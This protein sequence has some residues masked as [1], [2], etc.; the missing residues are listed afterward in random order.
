MPD[1]K[2]VEDP[3][4]QLTFSV[5]KDDEGGYVQFI[6][7]YYYPNQVLPPEL[8]VY[9][10]FYGYNHGRERTLLITP[11]HE[12]QW[13]S[14]I[15]IAIAKMASLN[16][17]V[18]SNTPLRIKRT[19]EWLLNAGAG[20]GVFGWVPFMAAHLG[21]YLGLGRA[22]I[23]IE[24]ATPANG[25]QVIN[26][27]HLNPLRCRLT[28]D[29]QYPVHYLSGDGVRKL[30]WHQVMVIVDMLDPTEGEM[31]LTMGATERAYKSIIKMAAID[32]YV[33]EKVSGARP[34]ALYFLGGAV[35][36]HIKDAIEGSELDADRK[37]IMS[38]RGAA[39][40]AVPGDIPLTL[41][42]IPLAELPDGFDADQERDRADLIYANAIGL[43][44]QDINPSLVGR[45][46]LGSSGNQSVVLA[47]KQRGR[48]LSAWMAQFSHA[49]NEL[50][51]NAKVLFTFSDPSP[52]EKQSE[53]DLSK[54]RA[55]TRKIQ[56]ETGEITPDQ[57]RNL[58]VD[59]GDLPREF[60]EV[61][62]TGG[63][64]L[65]DDAKILA[66]VKPPAGEGETG[67]QGEG[68]MEAL[69]GDIEAFLGT[70]TD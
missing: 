11:R 28:G 52:E 35:Q 58:A 69:V 9:S 6:L 27:H 17:A 5:K 12:G 60:I 15:G 39:V 64:V 13:A 61:D 45:Q 33:Y 14:A 21:A 50:A 23:E 62:E 7:P 31:R 10:S 30:G 36:R 34:Q 41:V 44:P 3:K 8:P 68:E 18:E 22:F 37:G 59:D 66:E 51:L 2:I 54:T 48:G 42:T 46:G 65:R 40:Q 25:S 16:W 56:I 53:V 26:I 43:D 49:L 24:R 1:T 32:S 67:R 47:R 70:T 29:P 4:R 55:E 38:F 63:N 20:L 19:Q 57:A